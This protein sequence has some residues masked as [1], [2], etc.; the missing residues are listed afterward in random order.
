MTKHSISRRTLV[1]SAAAAG[2]A[3][4][5]GVKAAD[6]AAAPGAVAPSS[7]TTSQDLSAVKYSRV[8][9]TMPAAFQEA[10][11]LK[12][13]VDAGTLPPV[14]ERI[15]EEPLVVEPIE[16]GQYGG[17]MRVGDMSTNLGGYD[18]GYATGGPNHFLRY[19]P[20][21]TGTEPNIAKSVDVSEDKTTYTL[22]LRRG[23]KW[24][25][26]KPLTSSD[27]M[28]TYEDI[29]MNE[30]LTPS[31]YTGFRPGDQPFQITAPDEYTIQIKFAVP[32]PAF[33]LSN[34]PHQ[35]GWPRNR[36]LHPRHYLEQFHPKY[37]PN[38][39]AE[40]TEAGFS[41]WMERFTDRD[42][43]ALNVEI[44]TL[45]AMIAVET[46]PTLVRYQRNP[47][48][49][50]VDSQGNQLPYL[51]GAVMERLQD[52]ENYHAKIVTGAYDYAVGNTSVLNYATYEGS[53][54]T[55][56]YR[57]LRW[58]SGRGGENFYQLN[59]NWPDAELRTIH[60]DVRY[61][62][63][64]SLAIN[65]QEMNDLLF[66]GA[67]VPRQMTVLDTSIYFKQEYADAW[68]QYDPD[69]AN[70][71]LDELGLAWNEDRSARLLPSGKPLKYAFDYFNGEGPK[72]QI[73]ELVSE[74]WR[75]IGIDVVG[76]PVTRQ[77]LAPR[78]ETNKEPMSMWHGD[79]ST[80]IL[81][82]VDRKWVT[83][84]LGDE[85]TIAP[86]WNAWWQNG[87]TEG[88]EPPEWY[89][90]ALNTWDKFSETLDPAVA[91]KLLKS[92]A[93]NLWSIGT[94]GM[95][96]WPFIVKNTIG[97]VPETGIHTWDGLFQYPYHPETL[98]IR[99]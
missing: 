89:L 81:L 52:V 65:R 7:A 21:L 12:A 8:I 33:L 15:S 5:L 4:A 92:Q 34:L 1:G 32:H 2:S 78:I 84:K 51:D 54:Q 59:L 74:Y 53:A 37:N 99:Q 40:A 77:L 19:T 35:Y 17:E 25:D 88:E 22:H 85:C 70:A 91:D 44:P 36:A 45:K 61:R 26:G 10:P 55:A 57:V 30:E 38:A 87:G 46:T 56:G 6:V 41:T 71:L 28:F 98:F 75:A 31:I 80:D 90:D 14:A 16:I 94:V 29:L 18:I 97:N 42:D 63:A 82:P 27:M 62:R 47:Y 3:A 11:M 66:F 24:S 13:M 76:T 79:A 48:F 83:G 95:T 43:E 67:A 60:Q 9:D 49:W 39:A 20:D 64:M 23:M 86:L 68:A 58:S 72:M 73:L 96:P 69:Q 93:D 50:A